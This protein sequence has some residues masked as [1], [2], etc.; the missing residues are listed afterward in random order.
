[1]YR[2]FSF[3]ALIFV[4]CSST[5]D[6]N[7]TKEDKLTELRVH[8][9]EKLKAIDPANKLDS[10]QLIRIDTLTQ[11]DKYG[12]MHEVLADSLNRIKLRMDLY[13][14]LYNA[15]L[16]L[17][18]LSKRSSIPE[19]NSYKAEAEE[20]KKELEQSEEESKH[21][22]L[23]SFYCDS[24][25]KISDTIKSIGYKAACLYQLRRKDR[26]VLNDTAY[27]LMNLNKDI[28][29]KEDFIKIP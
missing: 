10:F 1:M 9:D 15:N 25:L 2:V 19:Y 28:I 8:L 29:R 23:Q 21:L 22:E 7:A 3:C 4:A 26:S 12:F 6:H 18:N 5:S 16:K 13:A 17:A 14:E 11:R 20:N 27:I 24:L